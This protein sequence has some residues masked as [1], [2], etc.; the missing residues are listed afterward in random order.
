MQFRVGDPERNDWTSEFVLDIDFIVEWKCDGPMP[1]RV[2]PA[3]LKFLD[4][5]DLQIEFPKVQKT[6]NVGI[7]LP[8]IDSVER[9]LVDEQK[10]YL[11]R[12]YYDWRLTLYHVGEQGEIRFGA[13]E[14]SQVL[15][16]EPQLIDG[17]SLPSVG[18][19]GML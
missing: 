16:A 9:T 5:T 15:R 12:P 18:R 17:Q 13:T 19:A 14:F 2:A 1:F 10:V 11:D 3:T 6:G 4:V 8:C 7:S